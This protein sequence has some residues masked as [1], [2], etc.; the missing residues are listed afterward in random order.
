MLFCVE[1]ETDLAS[2]VSAGIHGSSAAASRV[3]CHDSSTW[4]V[5]PF[6]FAPILPYLSPFQFSVLLPSRLPVSRQSS[7]A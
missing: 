7:T 3:S 5:R 1:I 6:T 4:R 2:P